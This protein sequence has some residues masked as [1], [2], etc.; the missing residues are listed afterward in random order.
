MINDYFAYIILAITITAI[1]GPA[2]VLTI[3]NSLRYGYKSTLLNIFGNFI[4][5]VILASISAIGLGAIIL[6]SKTLFFI[7][8]ILGCFYL[9]YLGIKIWTSSS[10]EIEINHSLKKNKKESMLIFKE[11]FFVGISNPKA[12]A[13]FTALFPQFIDPSREYF[14]QFVTL[15]LTIECISFIVLFIYAIIAFKSANFIKSKKYSKLIN[16]LSALA[17]IGFGVALIYKD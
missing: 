14:L 16:K 12:I 5:M 2:V 8:K 9:I 13:F 7:L 6:A 4:A 17:F 15:I 3:K 10:W 1:P 11:G